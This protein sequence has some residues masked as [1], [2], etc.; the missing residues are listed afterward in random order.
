MKATHATAS[1]FDYQRS[2]LQKVS[3]SFALTI[4]QLPGD[5]ADVVGNAYLLCR[6]ADTLEDDAELEYSTKRTLLDEFIQV[7]NKRR[8]AASFG[9]NVVRALSPATPPDEI[10]LLANTPTVVGITFSF[11]AMQQ[12]ALVRCVD[13][14]ANGMPRF[15]QDSSLNGLADLG[16][17][18]DYC[19]VVAG[20]VGEMLTTLFCEHSTQLG[21]RREQMMGLARSFGQ[22]LQMTN[23][24][25]DIWADSRRGVCWLPRTSFTYL[26]SSLEQA[27]ADGDGGK[28]ARGVDQLV[29]VAHYHLRQALEYTHYLPRRESGI[30]RFC[31][32][33]IGLAVLTLRNIHRQPDFTDSNQVKVSRR[34]LQGVVLACN[35]SVYSNSTQRVLFSLAARGLPLAGPDCV[36]ASPVGKKVEPCLSQE[37]SSSIPS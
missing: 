13:I 9:A 30:R 15:Q 32:W 27:L 22:G 11:T 35:A 20:V 17:L 12:Q 23:I 21:A 8:D 6:I 10:D 28:L 16:E 14:M 37:T 24:L 5:L 36:A 34:A 3:R 7:L 19:Y 25:K 2:S 31:L 4:P 29:G 18:D 26:D 33:S 1:G